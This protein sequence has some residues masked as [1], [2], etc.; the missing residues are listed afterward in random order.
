MAIDHL[1][2]QL[3]A[4]ALE[5]V[6]SSLSENRRVK[7]GCLSY[8]DMLVTKQQIIQIYPKLVSEEFA[9]RED[10]EKVRTWHGMPHLTEIIDTTNFFEKLNC[11]V[12][13]FDFKEF[14]GGEI[15]CDLNLPLDVRYEGVYDI[16]IDTGTLEH[17]FNVGVAF[18]NMCKLVREGGVVVSA[19]PMTKI[20]HGFWNFS[21]CVYGNF[22]RQNKWDLLFMAGFY[23]ENGRLCQAEIP[24]NSRFFLPAE[25]IAI[26]VARRVAGS[27]FNL[28]TQQKYLDV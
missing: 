15:V 10:Y 20:N 23:K 2:F 5:K 6:K 24:E 8:P 12:D 7:V 9:L 26:V 13:Y 22:F 18:M 1:F 27:S 19:A 14:R 4:Q 3:M 17:C 16:V 11:E 21:P 28:P 25:S